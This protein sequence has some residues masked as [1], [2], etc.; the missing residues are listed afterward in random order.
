MI[1]G[2][3]HLGIVVKDMAKSLKALSQIVDFENPSI[4]EFPEKKMKCAVVEM[5][6]V[7]L[8]FLED[9]SQD[10]FLGKF[11]RERGDSIHHFCLLSDNLEK[12]VA[13]LK[14]KGVEMMD[15]EPRIGLRG[16]KIA[17]TSP[18]AL[19]GISIELSEP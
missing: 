16:K 9:N 12:D 10:G 14:E 2:I 19:D 6:G 17:F 5:N 8:E 18:D 3:G 7:A 1:K 15:L 4:K 11:N 13:D